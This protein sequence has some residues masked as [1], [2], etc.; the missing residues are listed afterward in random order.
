M[1]DF[2]RQKRAG[3]RNYTSKKWIGCAKVSFLQGVEVYQGLVGV[4]QE[5]YIPSGEKVVPD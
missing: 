3:Q 1:K 2:S 5:D 4:Y